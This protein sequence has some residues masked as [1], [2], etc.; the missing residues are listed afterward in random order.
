LDHERSSALSHAAAETELAQP[1]EWKP[2]DIFRRATPREIFAR[3]A[4]LEM[5]IGCGEGAFLMAM[6]KRHPERNFLATERLLGRVRNVVRKAERAGMT[7]VRVL[8]LESAYVIKH[9][10]PAES[11]TVAHILFPDPWPKR[12]HQARRL[13]QDE[14]VRDL[15]QVLAPAGELR[16]K[17]DDLPYFLW[18]EKVLARTPGFE[19]LEW[20][21][22]EDEPLT[23]FE[24]NF[25][26]KGLPIHRAR[27]RKV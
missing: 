27:L 15:H 23:G 20:A 13:F 25:L 8:R 21:P 14:F 26:A 17:T 6:A 22:E 3:E 1:V 18:M 10:M 9:L 7:N 4:L 12:Q 2:D 5:D 19:R 11:V 24:R 16:L